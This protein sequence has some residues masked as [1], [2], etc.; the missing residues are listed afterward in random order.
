MTFYIDWWE[1]DVPR[2]ARIIRLRD[3]TRYVQDDVTEEM[4]VNMPLLTKYERQVLMHQL[5]GILCRK[6]YELFGERI[7][8]VAPEAEGT[9]W[10][11]RYTAQRERFEEVKS[12]E[13]PSIE[14]G[15]HER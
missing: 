11:I 6:W 15:G 8:A 12:A 7:E 14:G 1:A 4:F 13:R 9:A 5:L 2:F 3:E 10:D